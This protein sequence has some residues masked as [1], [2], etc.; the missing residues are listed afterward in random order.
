MFVKILKS[1]ELRDCV[2]LAL[3][4]WKILIN[5]FLRKDISLYRAIKLTILRV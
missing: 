5:G 2:D 3:F 4:R 1:F